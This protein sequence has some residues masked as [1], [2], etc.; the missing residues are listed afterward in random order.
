MDFAK[1]FLNLISPADKIL[2]SRDVGFREAMPVVQEVINNVRI[3]RNES[4]F[5]RLWESSKTPLNETNI[6]SERR[7]TRNK[8]RSSL[9]TGFVITEKIGERN[10]DIKIEIK[11]AFYS[12][13]DIFLREMKNR[14]EDNVDILTAISESSEFC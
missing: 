4:T 12:V 10:K 7:P 13:I 11:S 8:T 9:L 2:Q 1:E 3:L 6:T 14:F 5:D